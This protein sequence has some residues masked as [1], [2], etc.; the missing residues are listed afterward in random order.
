[1]NRPTFSQPALRI[2]A[3]AMGIIL[4]SGGG[5]AAASTQQAA[6]VSPARANLPAFSCRLPAQGRRTTAA[7]R[8]NAVRVGTHAGYDRFV[9]Q[10]ANGLP[11]WSVERARPPLLQDPSGKPLAVAGRSFLKIT[12]HGA[13][14]AGSYSGPRT[15]TPRYAT[16]TQ[17]KNGGDFEMV[18]TWYA[19]LAS[20]KCVRVFTLSAPN[21]LVIDVEH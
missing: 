1:M 21:R 9:I 8:I 11:D 7:A 17:V 19:G 18:T 2:W 5:V 3:L 13:S 4:V 20:A 16:L 6:T 10:F 14:M 12:L 15:F